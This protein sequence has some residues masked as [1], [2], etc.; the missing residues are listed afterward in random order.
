MIGD[1]PVM[2]FAKMKPIVI[3]ET[4]ETAE[5]NAALNG[6]LDALKSRREKRKTL[7]AEA[8]GILESPDVK[9]HCEPRGGAHLFNSEYNRLREILDELERLR[10]GTGMLRT[11]E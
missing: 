9:I 8:R 7:I 5:L 10:S 6:A 1:S 4:V 2:A 11:E 3:F